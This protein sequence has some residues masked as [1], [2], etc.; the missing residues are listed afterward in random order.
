MPCLSHPSLKQPSDP[1]ARVWRYMDIAKLLSILVDGTLFFPS[2]KTLSNEDKTEGQPTDPEA[3]AINSLATPPSD[4]ELKT[5]RD[6]VVANFRQ[7]APEEQKN[8]MTIIENTSFFNCWHMNDD[9]SV[10]AQPAWSTDPP[11]R[12]ARIA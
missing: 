12:I 2:G 8:Q 7:A 10:S 6:Q 4:D 11:R 9:E 1:N 5:Y 3:D